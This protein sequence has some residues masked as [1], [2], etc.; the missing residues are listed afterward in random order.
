MNFQAPSKLNY[1]LQL[2]K[3]CS[4]IF[5]AQLNIYMKKI[6]VA[7]ACFCTIMS[8]AQTK[9]TKTTPP[10][11]TQSTTVLKTLNDSVSYAIGLSVANFYSQQGIKTLNST[12]V[13]KG[14]SDVLGKK[15][16]LLTDEQANMAVMRCL[17][18]NLSK[19]QAEGEK[20]L[21]A[22]KTKKGVKTTP[23]GLQYEVLVEGKGAR[24]AITDTVVV[25]YA[26]T[27]IN[28]TEFDNSYKR[29]QPIEFPLTGVIRGWTEGL[30]LMTAGSKYKFYIPSN[31]AYGPNDNQ[32][33]PGGSVLIFEVE[34]LNIKSKK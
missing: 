5:V 16:L 28:G 1:H 10:K 3:G 13:S 14:I 17:N 15:K 7:V 19:N 27:L 26:G 23:S 4:L 29:G 8:H 20:F 12:L 18:P 33:I 6:L 21:A 34:L 22:N 11:T 9:T 25:N 2:V 24:P 30:Q 31:L 32:A